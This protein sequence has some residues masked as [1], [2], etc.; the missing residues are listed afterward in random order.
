MIRIMTISRLRLLRSK[1]CTESMPVNW[2]PSIISTRKPRQS[3]TWIWPSP[4]LI[5]L[6]IIEESNWR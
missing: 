4:N 1:E 2:K 5:Y 6:N 3:S